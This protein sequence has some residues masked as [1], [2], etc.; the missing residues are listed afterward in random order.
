MINRDVCLPID[1]RKRD[2]SIVAV[3]TENRKVGIVEGTSSPN[4]MGEAQMNSNRD[5]SFV[6]L[7]IHSEREL[8]VAELALLGGRNKWKGKGC[9]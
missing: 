2:Q 9:C 7:P 1:S 4:Q 5:A 8:S 6:S 3:V